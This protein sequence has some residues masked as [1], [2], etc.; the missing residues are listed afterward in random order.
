M[1]WWLLFLLMVPLVSATGFE[2]HQQDYASFETVLIKT[3]FTD[4]VVS[5]EEINVKVEGV[6]IVGKKIVPV[7]DEYYIYFYLPE[8][9]EGEYTFLLDEVTVREDGL[10]FKDYTSSFNVVNRES[11]SIRPG[12][13]YQELSSF[14]QPRLRFEIE[15]K[16]SLTD[17]VLGVSD[18]WLELSENSFKLNA[19]NK[20]SVTVA[21]R[22]R[23]SNESFLEGSFNVGYG[24]FSYEVPV[25]FVRD[26]QL[27]VDEPI[28]DVDKPV[29]V[30][31][32]AL[33]FDVVKNG[34]SR[35]D[36]VLGV[37]ELKE[38][39][40]YF[41][42]D[43]GVAL[44]GL[45][46]SL[47][48]LEDIISYAYDGDNVLGVG[49]VEFVHITVN[50]E[51]S[52]NEDYSGSLQVC[53]G[54]VCGVLPI[55]VKLRVEEEDEPM[56]IPPGPDV[57]EPEVPEDDEGSSKLWIV[58]VVLGVIVIVFLVLYLKGRG[59]RRSFE[60]YVKKISR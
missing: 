29:E 30:D 56:A 8:V 59:E 27:Q 4:D 16:G 26:V 10:V 1:K 34:G 31:A 11:V 32:D 58:F 23:R 21:S 50:S 24:G 55:T 19:G 28:D 3:N 13:I 20:R 48:G 5:L 18:D 51:R 6:N 17:F 39:D 44:E 45:V 54:A 46:F 35:V 42:N 43:G 25:I 53:S 60:G 14:E 7:N 9:S 33:K 15:N 36:L 12:L 57:S 38:G 49:E 47:E 2:F 40:M 41:R 22:V 37:N 52:L